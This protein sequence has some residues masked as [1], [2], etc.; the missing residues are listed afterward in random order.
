MGVGIG[1]AYLDMIFKHSPYRQNNFVPNLTLFSSFHSDHSTSTYINR[2]NI[3]STVYIFIILCMSRL[4]EYVIC[5]AGHFSY[6][7]SDTSK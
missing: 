1:I 6:S 3:N 4:S 5:G 2:I 7:K